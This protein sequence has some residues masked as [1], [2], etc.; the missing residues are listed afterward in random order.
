MNRKKESG[1]RRLSTGQWCN[2]K[3]IH[4]NL[5]RQ[6]KRKSGGYGSRKKQGNKYLCVIT[7]GSCEAIMI[8]Y[9]TNG[10]GLQTKNTISSEYQYKC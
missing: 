9:F 5:G 2:I 10:S 1:D 3:G 8:D 4:W 7:R 6:W